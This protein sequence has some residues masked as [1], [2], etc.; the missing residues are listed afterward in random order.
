MKIINLGT[1]LII[2][3]IIL[4]LGLLT[5]ASMWNSFAIQELTNIVRLDIQRMNNTANQI[6]VMWNVIK[7]LH[8][9]T[10]LEMAEYRIIGQVIELAK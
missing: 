3:L 2:L 7:M 5:I 10:E 9:E 6:T 4:T 8:S 1:N